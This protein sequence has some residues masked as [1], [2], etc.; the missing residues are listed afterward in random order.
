MFLTRWP[1]TIKQQID[2]ATLNAATGYFALVGIII[3][4]VSALVFTLVSNVLPFEV[5][6][7]L[8]MIASLAFTGA[9]HED[10]LA[11]TA[12]GLGGGWDVEAKLNIMKDSRI[13]TYGAC[14]LV[15]C[16]LLKFQ[17][18]LA[19]ANVSITFVITGL[20]LGH[21]VSRAFAVSLIGA[22]EYVQLDAQ[23]KTKPVAQSLTQNSKQVLMMTVGAVLFGAWFINSLSLLQIV[24]LLLL[25]YFV[26][27][28]FIAFIRKQ[29]GG[30]T[31]DILGAAQQIFELSIYTSLLVFAGA[32][33]TGAPH[34]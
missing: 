23:S 17:L 15:L 19:L 12:D 21:S 33:L 7:I 2:D 10:G 31:G 6:V 14:A 1:L 26:R 18:L 13:G 20:I 30:Y 25:L 32:Q 9:F 4:V 27:Y 5:A 34:G 28:L 11:D 22:L 3:A 29:L 24:M 16:L 8:S